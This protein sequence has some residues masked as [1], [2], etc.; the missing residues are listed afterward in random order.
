[1]EI[2]DE[3]AF[4]KITAEIVSAYVSNNMVAIDDLPDLIRTVQHT[5]KY[6]P[7]QE[8]GPATA[9]QVPAVPI[10][11]SITDSHLVCLEDGLHFKS[12]KRHLRTHHQLTPE[13]YRDRWGLSADYPMVAPD[14]SLRRSALARKSGLG[15]TRRR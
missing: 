13:Q 11:Q 15:K 6:L 7:E 1:M 9:G 5:L 3:L 10:D 8:A 14:Y 4:T 12:L 2:Q